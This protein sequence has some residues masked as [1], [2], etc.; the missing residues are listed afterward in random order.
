MI[1]FIKNI[2]DFFS[3]NYFDE[4]FSNKVIDKSGFSNESHK[5]FNS[6]IGSIKDK[7]FRYKL[8]MLEGRLR[9]KDKVTN[10]SQN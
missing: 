1:K 7:Y 8:R 4:D 10:Q 3:T 9:I 6:R 2:G 5:L